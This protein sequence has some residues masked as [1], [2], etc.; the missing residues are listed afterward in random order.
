MF[1]AN[2]LERNETRFMIKYILSVSR[3][4]F[5]IMKGNTSN[6]EFVSKFR[7]LYLSHLFGVD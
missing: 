6:S 3:L 7:S 4:V 5:E 1:D 2:V